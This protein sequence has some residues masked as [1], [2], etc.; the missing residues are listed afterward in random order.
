MKNITDSQSKQ[1][2]ELGQEFDVVHCKNKAYEEFFSLLYTD[3]ANKAFSE[4]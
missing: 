2:F 4:F 3:G 1:K